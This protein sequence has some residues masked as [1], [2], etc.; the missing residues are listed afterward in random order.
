MRYCINTAF[1]LLFAY[2]GFSQT[3]FTK[4]KA[5]VKSLLEKFYTDG[6][7]SPFFIE[8]DSSLTLMFKDST[9][10]IAKTSYSY[11]FKKNGRCYKET[12]NGDCAKCF[13]EIVRGEK[14]AKRYGWKKISQSLYISKPFWQMAIVYSKNEYGLT[15]SVINRYLN[16]DEHSR[17]Y[18]SKN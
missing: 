11:Y 12:G 10:A 9:G 15:Y 8:T 14:N 6:G 2:S 3:F 1:F 18:R 17:M 5:K 7:F 13:D 16:R 4:K